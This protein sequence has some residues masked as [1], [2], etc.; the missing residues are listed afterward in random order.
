VQKALRQIWL[1]RS[2]SKRFPSGSTPNMRWRPMSR[3]KTLESRLG[4]PKS[5]R[6]IS[7]WRKDG[8][9]IR[10]PLADLSKIDLKSA[11]VQQPLFME[12]VALSFVIP[13][14]AEDSALSFPPG[15]VPHVCVGA[16]GA[17]HGLNKMGRSPF[18]CSLFT[19]SETKETRSTLPRRRE[20]CEANLSR[21]AVEGSA[22]PRTSP[23]NAKCYNSNKIVIST[24]A[25]GI[26]QSRNIWRW[27]CSGIASG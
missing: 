9:T 17:L 26:L 1:R 8:A 14:E 10:P 12:T 16:A 20:R 19:C 18:R 3:L 2:D 21:R 7:P 15:R 22:V 25:S 27:K 23:G 6:S 11:S 13:S 4:S 5:E 24:G